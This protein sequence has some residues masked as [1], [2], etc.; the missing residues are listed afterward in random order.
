MTRRRGRPRSPC[1]PQRWSLCLFF[2]IEAGG[3]IQTKQS[4]WRRQLSNGHPAHQTRREPCA[5]SWRLCCNIWG[6]C[7][8]LVSRDFFDF[9]KIFSMLPQNV[10]IESKGY[11]TY[12]PQEYRTL[13]ALHSFSHSLSFY[14]S[15]CF[16]RFSSV[17]RCLALSTC[18]PLTRCLLVVVCSGVV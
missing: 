3:R 10:K 2:P 1:C 15:S 4:E 14:F 12:W 9:S 17:P 18:L 16:P 13:A 5:F 6:R 7:A 8:T 11:S